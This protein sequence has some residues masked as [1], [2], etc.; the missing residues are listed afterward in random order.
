M[1]KVKDFLL[2][3]SV[4][5]CK[6]SRKCRKSGPAG[7]DKSNKLWHNAP[8]NF[9]NLLAS[10]RKN[11]KMNQKE[12]RE[13]RRRIQPEHNS[14]TRIYGC[15]VNGSREI[16]TSLEESVGLLPMEEQEKYMALL[17]KILSGA[18]GKNLLDLSFA[19]K[20]VMEGEAYKL[21][22]ALR[23][24]EGKDPALLE[25]FYQRVIESADMDGENYLILLGFDRYDVPRRGKDGSPDDSGEV[26]QYMLCALCPVKAGKAALGYSPEEKRFHSA[27]E[28]QI[29][30]APAL[31]F[32]YP[33]FDERCTNI[34]HALLYTRDAS[35]TPESFIDGVFHTQAPLSAGEQRES[36]EAALSQS[37]EKDCRFELVQSLHEQLSER[38]QLHKESKD[39]EP[40]TL[41]LSE[42][43][44]ILENSGASPEEA[45]AF[46]RRYEEEHGKDALLRPA[47]LSDLRKMAINTPQVKIQVDPRFSYLVQARELEGKKVILIAA[48]EGVELNGVPVEI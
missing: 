8:A 30:S 10:E 12:L 37:L 42:M 11:D 39:P 28:G 3:V 34:Y 32:L 33:C 6:D 13:I 2:S 7:L 26:Y 14:I 17:K 21:L 1:V 47:N 25:S 41:S 29:V 31:G 18:L 43:G 15:Y 20:E 22:S 48:D 19:T 23:K 24:S 36:F 35:Q 9:Q 46:C 16:I 5:I 38:E 44:D 4:T 40:L 27:A 45:E